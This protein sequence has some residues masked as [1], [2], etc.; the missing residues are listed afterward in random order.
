MMGAERVRA[1][2]QDRAEDAGGGVS[3]LARAAI[4]EAERRGFAPTPRVFELFFAYLDGQD[5]ELVAAVR[6]LL[7]EGA[8]P[9]LDAVDRIFDAHLSLDDQAARYVEI[10]HRVARELTTLGDSSAERL[11]RD[12]ELRE[13]LVRAREGMSILSRPGSVRQTIRDLLETTDGYARQTEAFTA[14]I[15]AS[16]AKINELAP[17]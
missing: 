13:H 3:A 15:R 10:G 5:A 7:P 17:S 8:A 14:Q 12:E 6:D 1:T 9:D 16:Q 2:G 4:A 11:E